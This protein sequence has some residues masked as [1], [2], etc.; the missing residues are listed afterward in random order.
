MLGHASLASRP[1]PRTV[2]FRPVTTVAVP[3]RIEI[4]RA[5]RDLSEATLVTKDFEAAADG[6]RR[7]FVLGGNGLV[8]KN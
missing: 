6:K 2:L 1:D 7:R 3:I 5:D 8:E 4:L